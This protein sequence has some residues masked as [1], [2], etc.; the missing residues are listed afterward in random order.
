MFENCC[1]MKDLT[2]RNLKGYDEYLR[3]VF[4]DYMKLPPANQLV[5]HHGFVAFWKLQ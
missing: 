5:A 4:G 1:D 3:F 2:I